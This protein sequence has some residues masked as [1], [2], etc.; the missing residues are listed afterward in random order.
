MDDSTIIIK[1][2][3]DRRQ[4]RYLKLDNDLE[5]LL[6]SDPETQIAA[7]SLSVSVGYFNNLEIDGIAHF[8]EHMLFMGSEKYPKENEYYTVLK[9]NGGESNAYTTSDNTTYYFSCSPN[10]L[11]DV[12]DV[13]SQFFVSPLF[14]Q[15]SLDREM[16]AVDSEFKNG[17]NNDA[18]RFM[19]ATKNFMREGHPNSKFSCGNLETLNIKGIREKVIDFYEKYYSAH[20]MKLVVLGK[21]SLD[22]L[23]KEIRD[24]FS[25]IKKKNDIV[26][27][28]NFGYQY[29]APIYGQIIPFSD[30]KQLDISWEFTY[31]NQFEFNHIDNFISHIV[32]HE[33]PGSLFSY[34][35]QNFLAK[36][37]NAGVTDIDKVNKSLTVSI[38][39]T[40]LGFS[41]LDVVINTVMNYIRRLSLATYEEFYDLYKEVEDTA[42][43][44]FENY[45]LENPLNICVSKSS[46][47]ATKDI[48]VRNLIAYDYIYE[49]YSE[50]C[51][52]FIIELFRKCK[53]NNS[54]IFSSS[55]SYVDNNNSFQTDKHYGVQFKKT[56]FPHFQDLQV[57]GTVTGTVPHKNKYICHKTDILE[58]NNDKSIPKLIKLDNMDLWWK[59]DTSFRTPEIALIVNVTLDG[60]E[61]IYNYQIISKLY[62][63]C[64]NHILNSEMYNINAA[65]Y[66]AS[67][68]RN[69]TGFSIRINGYPEK[70]M[71][72]LNY[73]ISGILEIKKM[74]TRDIFDNIKSNYIKELENTV[75]KSPVSNIYYELC[76]NVVRNYVPISDQLNELQMVK[77][78]DLIN[79][80]LFE[81]PANVIGICQGNIDENMA[82]ILAKEFER[83]NKNN[84]KINIGEQLKDCHNYEFVKVSENK[85]DENSCYMLATKLGYLNSNLKDM[86]CI[87]VLDSILSEQ[88]FDQLRTKE[89]L[90]Y[91][92]F[93]H[94]TQ[95]C[96]NVGMEY[97]IYAFIVQ[98]P[99][100]SC[101][102]LK[103][104]TYRF[105]R[106]FR[107][108]L[109]NTDEESIKS[110]VSSKIETLGKFQTLTS[111][112]NYNYLVI[113]SLN[114]RFDTIE[115]QKKEYL[116]IN[117]DVLVKCY[118][119]YFLDE[120]S[121]FGM[122]IRSSK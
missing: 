111:I 49:D 89:Q 63:R 12:L 82:K 44:A 110:I 36:S 31:M 33:G 114:C 96:W 11:I 57:L 41:K 3:K 108:I 14:L 87:S 34:L 32:G 72:V 93:S 118:D 122:S 39:L 61:N 9:N 112:A 5:I 88:Y 20:L 27:S 15:D 4:F 102:F 74:F 81:K 100:K 66:T 105:I 106:E 94:M 83:L 10:G 97:Y 119:K 120:G 107:D 117:K 98:S 35:Q 64:I 68:S 29:D 17:L 13:F 45:K 47:W 90:G 91:S 69:N 50:S 84:V 65:G 115:L 121:Y 21:E 54:I 55:N 67:I 103:E 71:L 80:E 40:D 30:V 43:I 18:M 95:L 24:K 42:K 73:I 113:S 16:N 37:L 86:T 62:F 38:K 77:Y 1:S 51:H 2:Q 99:N 6:I 116:N 23:E 56:V 75:F 59:F 58:G 7:A 79:Y 109:V 22:T 8:L 52:D 19:V 76:T 48:S 46:F 28:N 85:N 60:Q 25:Q 104:R 92:I 101:E 26:I 53:Y 70:F 78:E